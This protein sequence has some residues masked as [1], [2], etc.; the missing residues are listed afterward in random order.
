MKILIFSD[1]HG[2]VGDMLDAVEREKPDRIFHLGDLIRDA[3]D[4][5][6]AYPHIPVD[7][8]VGNCDGWTSGAEALEVTAGG[9]RFLLV[10][11]HSQHAKSGIAGLL[12]AGWERKADVVCFGH[13]HQPYLERQSDGMWLVNPGTAGGVYRS[14]TCLVAEIQDSQVKFM[15]KEM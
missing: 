11:G 7:R 4:V 15:L 8:V 9:V 2:R 6:A 3:D 14:A 12:R 10:H 1:S 5:A 13:T